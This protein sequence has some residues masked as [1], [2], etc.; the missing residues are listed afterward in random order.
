MTFSSKMFARRNY[1]IY[2]YSCESEYSQTP[3]IFVAR[4]KLWKNWFSTALLEI[5]FL[6]FFEH[7]PFLG[8]YCFIT[9]WPSWT[10]CYIREV[11]TRCR[12]WVSY[13]WFSFSTFS[14]CWLTSL[15]LS[16]FLRVTLTAQ[17]R[18]GSKPT[19]TIEYTRWW[20]IWI[21]CAE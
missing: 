18:C 19:Y 2:Y 15:S 10:T 13:F 4:K 14:R 3:K 16:T 6:R 9:S 17:K 7:K 5:C 8:V 20:G 11:F 1:H 12:L 21:D